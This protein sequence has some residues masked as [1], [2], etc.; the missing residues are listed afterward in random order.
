MIGIFHMGWD[1]GTRGVVGRLKEE[2]DDGGPIWLFAG[3]W[4]MED[5]STDDSGDGHGYGHCNG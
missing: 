4:M 3:V 5:K 1:G 2:S